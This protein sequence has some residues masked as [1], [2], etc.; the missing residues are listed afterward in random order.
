TAPAHQT[1]PVFS[2]EAYLTMLLRSIRYEALAIMKSVPFI[3]IVL[4]A[5]LFLAINT[6]YIGYVFG[7]PGYPVTYKILQNLGGQFIVFI[8]IIIT[9]FSG[10]TVWRS[11]E[12]KFHPILDALPVPGWISYLAKT[13]AMSLILL[14]LLGVV[15]IAGIIVQ[16]IRGYYH[17]ELALYF[18]DLLGYHYPAYI[19]LAAL[20]IAVQSVVPNKFMGHFVMILYYMMTDFMEEFGFQHILYAYGRTIGKIYSDMNGYGHYV[21]PHIVLNAYWFCIAALL[22]VIGFLFRPHGTELHLRHRLR[23][24]RNRW[25][26]GLRNT[27]LVLIGCGSALGGYIYYNTNILNQYRT[28]WEV[29]V[30][31]VEYER[32]YKQ[33]EDV[34]MPRVTDVRLDVELYPEHRAMEA[35]GTFQLVNSAGVPLEEIYLTIPE[36]DIV[37]DA[38]TLDRPCR[39]GIDDSEHRFFSLI[40]ETAVQPGETVTMSFSVAYRPRGFPNARMNNDFVENGTFFN[41]KAYLPTIGYWEGLEL[42]GDVA[43]RKHDLPTKPRMADLN[44]PAQRMNNY[45]TSDADWIRYEAVIGTAPD[46]LAVTCG[47]L[48]REWL[49]DGRRYFHYRMDRPMINFYPILSARYCVRSERHNG[50]DYSIYYHPG[51]EW[52]LDRMM[53][54]MKKSIDYYSAQFSPFQ[55]DQLRIIEFP[56]YKS[57]AQSFANTIPYSE[58]AGFVAEITDDAVDYPFGITAHETAHQWW[59]HQVIGANVQGT[60]MLT[61]MLAQYGE[62]MMARNEYPEKITRKYLRYELDHYL[63]GRSFEA[64]GEL[65]MILNENQ[66]YIHYSKSSMIMNL[67]QDTLGAETVNLALS[68]F[69]KD[70]AYPDPP[71]PRSIDLLP[72]FY[73][74]CPER[75]RYLITD[76]FERIVLYDNKVTEVVVR[77]VDEGGYRVTISA[78]ARKS[79]VEG[80]GDELDEPLNDWIEFGVLDENGEVLCLEKHLVGTDAPNVT[81]HVDRAPAKA[82]IDPLNKLIDKHPGDN[83][84]PCSVR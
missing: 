57:F 67:L 5:V 74:V 39:R 35:R 42:T 27:V 36:T 26:P 41:N 79:C 78:T 16:T 46:Q 60:T 71:Y 52:N 64:Y 28:S 37:I 43:R 18:I 20:T 68:D 49:A 73:R 19:L 75:Y 23:V 2:T 22:L 33:Y 10:E 54:A 83:V 25:T 4:A 80:L 38:L 62:L 47:H 51:H 45:V 50:V 48:V 17:Y 9:F 84:T 31:Q 81:L 76:V 72:Y 55:F 8:L 59:A 34:P 11:R 70:Y 6:R 15:F 32:L 44:D 61:E 69:L 12:Q 65:P 66:G 40:P 82:G 3:I 7:T 63:R 29:E 24:A 14:M 53:D 58:S 77:P 56:R 21:W 13:G 30:L 1:P